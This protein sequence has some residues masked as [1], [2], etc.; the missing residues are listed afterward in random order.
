MSELRPDCQVAPDLKLRADEWK[1]ESVE[2]VNGDERARQF[3][4]D[5]PHKALVGNMWGIARGRMGDGR[6]FIVEKAFSH[7]AFKD[8]G[9]DRC[10]EI[11]RASV[12]PLANSTNPPALASHHSFH[13]ERK[14]TDGNPLR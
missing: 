1:I 10:E 3:P 9:V 14:R 12:Q 8:L 7:A 11:L 5:A 2:F 13:P 4:F 6:P